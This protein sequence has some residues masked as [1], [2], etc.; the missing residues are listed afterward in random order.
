MCHYEKVLVYDC[1]LMSSMP[2]SPNSLDRLQDIRSGFLH[3][4][5]ALLNFERRHY[6]Q[7]HGRMANSGEFFRLVVNDQ[8]FSWL[9]PMS[10]FIV[11]I[12]ETLAAKEPIAED[13]VDALLQTAR[14]LIRPA[15]EGNFQEQ[16][17]FQAIQGDPEIAM[18]HAEV[19]AVLAANPRP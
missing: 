16:R 10:Q 17:Y 11:Q 19:A 12:D 14:E 4:H 1:C 2:S 5:K 9:R 18:L 13:Q 3:L 6:E 7:L 8:W 15:K